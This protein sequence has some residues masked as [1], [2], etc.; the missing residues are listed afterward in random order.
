MTNYPSAN[1]YKCSVENCDS[2]RTAQKLCNKHYI[3]FKKHGDVTITKRNMGNGKTLQEKFW[4]KAILTA[5][6]QK[7]WLWQAGI[8]CGYGQFTLSVEG[9]KET[10]AHRVAF[11]LFYGISPNTLSVCHKCDTTACVNPHHLFL[12]TAADNSAD[13]VNKDR[14]LKGE[15]HLKSKLT[16]EDVVSIKRQLL[17]GRSGTELSRVFNVNHTTI[18][19]IKLGHSWNHISTMEAK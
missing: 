10:R 13:M 19:R 16:K 7:C 18:S 12:G 11:F 14:S 6:P 1:K 9:K 2:K 5:N 17:Q 3:R 15:R 4:S 8:S